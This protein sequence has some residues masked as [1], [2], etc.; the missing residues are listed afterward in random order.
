LGQDISLIDIMVCEFQSLVL[1]FGIPFILTFSDIFVL[2][3][4]YVLIFI[5]FSRHNFYSYSVLF[6]PVILSLYLC[7]S[8]KIIFVLIS[9]SFQALC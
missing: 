7:Y 9:F 4:I 2:I 8:Q 6:L 3:I 1:W 5:P